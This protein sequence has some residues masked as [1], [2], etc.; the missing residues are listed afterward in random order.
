MNGVFEMKL[1]DLEYCI[2]PAKRVAGCGFAEL[3]DEV[4][5]FFVRRWEKAF[6]DTLEVARPA[7]G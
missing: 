7:T 3:H 2:L 6:R 4:F 5:G 1:E